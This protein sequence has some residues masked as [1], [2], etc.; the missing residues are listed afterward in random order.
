MDAPDLYANAFK[1]I[2]ENGTVYLMGRVTKREAERASDIA[3]SVSGVQRVVRIFDI[4]DEANLLQQEVPQ[5][6]AN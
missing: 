3:R 6:P 5:T 1:V 2:T 4:V